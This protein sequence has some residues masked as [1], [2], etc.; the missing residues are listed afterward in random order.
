MSKITGIFIPRILIVGAPATTS[1][2]DSGR[3][4][5]LMEYLSEYQTTTLT[6]L[7]G[8][9]SQESPLVRFNSEVFSLDVGCKISQEE[10]YTRRI[11]AKAPNSSIARR[12]ISR[13][14]RKYSTYAKPIAE[15]LTSYQFE[16]LVLV[17][18]EALGAVTHLAQTGQLDKDLLVHYLRTA[19][20]KNSKG[21]I[22]SDR[23]FEDLLLE[24]CR[25][26]R[27]IAIAGPKPVAM[28]E[29]LEKRNN[30][31]IEACYRF[32][33]DDILPITSDQPLRV[34][35]GTPNPRDLAQLANLVHEELA[36]SSTTDLLFVGHEPPEFNA[37]IC[38]TPE[39]VR[40]SPEFQQ[41]IRRQMSLWTH[42]II[43]PGVALLGQQFGD[44]Q[45][46]EIKALRDNGTQV[47]LWVR[48][49]MT[50]SLSD[51]ES[52]A[53]I[54]DV[55]FVRDER[56]AARIPNSVVLDLDTETA[57]TSSNLFPNAIIK[58]FLRDEA[59][60]TEAM[61]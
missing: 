54:C 16:R 31:P 8:N 23:V 24:E 17:G 58:K 3:L 49:E 12:A 6:L 27:P 21:K 52:L 41:Y 19:Q 44:N 34:L 20:A 42:A 2:L 39:E 26:T 1:N 38:V 29:D 50:D 33:N 61:R 10:R 55:C 5:R 46:N 37:H 35:I 43:E 40:F 48:S 36:S 51:I 59:S 57:A 11:A 7:L 30:S 25:Q 9:T 15:A 22:P 53:A 4:R 60:P 47:A 28:L 56:L 14:L 32:F 18:P 13:S 45:A